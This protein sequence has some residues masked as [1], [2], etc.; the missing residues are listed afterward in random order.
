MD[1][2]TAL[3]FYGHEYTPHLNEIEPQYDE[4]NCIGNALVQRKLNE[5]IE[6]EN[7]FAKIL[8]TFD[9]KVIVTGFEPTANSK[10]T[11]YVIYTY[12]YTL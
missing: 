9:I 7:N 12:I 6:T 10:S 3:G 11:L 5:M 8:T 4:R 2:L 1:P